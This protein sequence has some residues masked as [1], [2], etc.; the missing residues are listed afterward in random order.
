MTIVCINNENNEKKL[1]IG[2]SYLVI[3]DDV[4]YYI[5]NDLNYKW[6]YCKELFKTLFEIRNEK[7][8]KLLN[9]ES[10]MYR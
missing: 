9:D 1:T 5:T 10:K 7:I 6:F 2:K 8:D 4:Y 3:D